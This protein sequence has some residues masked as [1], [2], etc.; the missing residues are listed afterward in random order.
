MG[1]RSLCVFDID[2][3]IAVMVFDEHMHQFYFTQ[4]R[5][6]DFFNLYITAI[7]S[8][9]VIRHPFCKGSLHRRKRQ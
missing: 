8:V 3:R 2:E 4:R 7:S 1:Y 9:Y 6:I 5:N